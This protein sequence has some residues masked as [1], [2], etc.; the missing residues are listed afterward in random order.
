MS[1]EDE[2]HTFDG[3]S[4]IF[5]HWE[6]LGWWKRWKLNRAIKKVWRNAETKM[7]PLED[8]NISG[9]SDTRKKK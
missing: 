8:Q 4:P 6:K 2:I 7:E 3:D 5:T 1:N 9:W